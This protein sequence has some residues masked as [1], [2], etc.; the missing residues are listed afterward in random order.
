MF[1]GIYLLLQPLQI[2]EFLFSFNSF[3][4]LYANILSFNLF[5]KICSPLIFEAKS[6]FI[7]LIIFNSTYYTTYKF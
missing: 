1:A 3:N 4:L 7:F 6:F 2:G 5:L